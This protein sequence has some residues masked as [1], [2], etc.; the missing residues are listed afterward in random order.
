MLA[1]EQSAPHLPALIA[2]QQK[3]A[4]AEMEKLRKSISAKGGEVETK[5]A[6]GAPAEQITNYVAKAGV[7]LI[8]TSTHGHSGLRRVFMG[9]T[10]ARLV[11][12]ASCPVL[13]VPNRA[14]RAKTG[15][16]KS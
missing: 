6:L 10:A 15:K 3:Y 8:I 5:L 7:D 13:V 4:R 1:S 11:R 12:Y 2:S 16:V 9:S 14:S